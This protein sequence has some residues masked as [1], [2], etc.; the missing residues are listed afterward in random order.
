VEPFASAAWL[1]NWSR[2]DQGVFSFGTPATSFTL[3]TATWDHAVRY[4]LGVMGQTR[5]GRISAFLVGNVDDGSRLESFT[6]NAGLRFN[7]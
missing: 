1:K 3:D 2:G 4:S 6:V 5:D 7:F